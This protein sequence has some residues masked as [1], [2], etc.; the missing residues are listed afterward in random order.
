MIKTRKELKF[1]LQED[2][3]RNGFVKVGIKYWIQLL[4]G[5]ENAKAYSYL[6]ALRH[7]EFHFGKK[8]PFHRFVYVYWQL[9]RT[10]KG[11]RYHI[12]IPLN[13]SGY[14]LRIM[15]LSGG[16]YFIECQ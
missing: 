9:K 7:A 10:I 16:G 3:K 11:N 2:G 6:R 4:V 14:G 8:S 12:Q 13:K 1:Y 15:H 5:D